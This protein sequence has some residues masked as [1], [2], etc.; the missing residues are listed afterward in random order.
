MIL[1]YVPQSNVSEKWK[2]LT[3]TEAG[4]WRINGEGS[5]TN[6]D[7]SACPGKWKTP[8]RGGEQISGATE[9]SY[10]GGENLKTP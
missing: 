2:F 1:N 10:Y 3:E 7:G 5:I 8:E 6:Q 4:V 9:R